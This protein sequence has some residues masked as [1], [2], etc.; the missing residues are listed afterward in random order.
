M[1]PASAQASGSC[2]ITTACGQKFTIDKAFMVCEAK[3]ETQH[4]E[5]FTPSVIEPSFGIDRVLAPTRA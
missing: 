2:E 5:V 3:T 4:V 1:A